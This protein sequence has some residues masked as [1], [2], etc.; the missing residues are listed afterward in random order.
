MET[1]T[2]Q[3][4]GIAYYYC[5]YREHSIQTPANL[6]ASLL[7][8]FC[9]QKESLPTPVSD[10]YN[11]YRK[12]GV[13]LQA[14]ELLRVLRKVLGEFDQSFVAVDALDETDGKKQRKGFLKVLTDLGL[15]STKI[16]VTSRPHLQDVTQTFI[17]ASKIQIEATEI[18]I[19]RFLSR[20]IEDDEGMQ[21][22]MDEDLKEEVCGSIAQH[23]KGMYVMTHAIPCESVILKRCG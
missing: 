22:L 20:M 15:T 6:V 19:R 11:L 10:F 1:F 12:D 23:A 3:N 7:R 14:D 18:D 13:R 9:L 5:D 16:F 4:V 2:S 17:N 8:Q 21:D